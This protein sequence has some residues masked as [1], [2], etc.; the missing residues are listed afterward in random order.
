[1]WKFHTSM[2]EPAH[3]R[4]LWLTGVGCHSCSPGSMRHD[5]VKMVASNPTYHFTSKHRHAGAES[6][7]GRPHGVQELGDE[8]MIHTMMP[9]SFTSDCFCD[10]QPCPDNAHQRG[11]TCSPEPSPASAPSPPACA[12]PPSPLQVAREA[13]HDERHHALAVAQVHGQARA[14]H[15]LARVR[16]QGVS[17]CVCVCLRHLKHLCL[18]LASSDLDLYYLTFTYS[19]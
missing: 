9:G 11:C 2:F 10:S 3:V 18:L 1:M 5:G 16:A 14:V 13:A 4:P 8:G 19:I 7:R 15:G 6:S 17:W 12:P